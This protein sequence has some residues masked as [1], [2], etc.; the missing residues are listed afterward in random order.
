MNA[1]PYL[2][3]TVMF[4]ERYTLYHK[5]IVASQCMSRFQIL[6]GEKRFGLTAGQ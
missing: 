6:G 4:L 1:K 5:G 3:R 2:H